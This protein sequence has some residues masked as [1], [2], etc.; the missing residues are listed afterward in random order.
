MK[1]TELLDTISNIIEKNANKNY[2]FV[3]LRYLLIVGSSSKKDI[4]IELQ[5]YNQDVKKDYRDAGDVFKVLTESKKD[6]VTEKDQMFSINNFDELNDEQRYSLINKCGEKI[7]VIN[8]IKNSGS[9]PTHLD[10]T[11]KDAAF[12]V[13]KEEN[14][15]LNRVRITDLILKRHYVKEHNALTPY[16]TVARDMDKD[17][18]NS[19][20]SLFK[21][22]EPGIYGLNDSNFGLDT[23]DDLLLMGHKLFLMNLL[24]QIKLRLN[25]LNTKL[26]P[27]LIMKNEFNTLIR[28][29]SPQ[30]ADDLFSGSINFPNYESV[31]YVNLKVLEALNQNITNAGKKFIIVDASSHLIKH[32]RLPGYL[33]SEI[34]KKYCKVNGIGYIPLSDSLNESKKMVWKHCGLSMGI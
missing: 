9:M 32:G 25:N 27:E 22:L 31:I 16:E 15:P 18:E 29:F 17:I 10:M 34:L 19:N 6:L 14:K 28:T 26:H 12:K 33:L 21:K 5:N 7:L 8:K 3:M 23:N 30:I 1:F 24:N 4:A 20:E 13:L 2:Q 11:W